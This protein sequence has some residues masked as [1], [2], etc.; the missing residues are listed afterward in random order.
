MFHAYKA[1]IKDLLV[2]EK[3]RDYWFLDL[4]HHPL[5]YRTLEEHNV[6]DTL[7][8]SILR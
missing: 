7:S 4:V 8:V 1:S 5:F 6:T 3:I 2:K